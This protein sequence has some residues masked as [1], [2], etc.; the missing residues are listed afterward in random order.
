VRQ[1]ED[2]YWDLYLGTYG[3]CLPPKTILNDVIEATSTILREKGEEGL[4]FMEIPDN[5]HKKGD[6]VMRDRVTYN[7]SGPSEAINK[8]EPKLQKNN[9]LST[10]LSRTAPG[11]DLPGF[12]PLRKDFDVEFDNNAESS[13]ASMEF[14]IET[15]R[16]EEHPR[17]KELKLQVIRMYNRRLAER[18]ER[19]RFVI[20]GG[21]V[22]VK[23]QQQVIQIALDIG[24]FSSFKQPIIRFLVLLDAGR[25]PSWS[26][27]R[28]SGA[29]RSNAYFSPVYEN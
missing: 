22:E 23:K 26:G 19:K 8:K 17:E 12:L 24:Q 29:M 9:R 18:E 7:K 4:D 6:M 11:A 25:T 2:H 5:Q 16:G 3:H 28:R 20:E 14:G 15:A 21:Y 27:T 13:L 10:E 1:C